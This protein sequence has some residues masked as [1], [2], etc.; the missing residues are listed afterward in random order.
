VWGIGNGSKQKRVVRD[1]ATTLRKANGETLPIPRCDPV[2]QAQSEAARGRRSDTLTAE[3]G[4][5][6]QLEAVGIRAA[7]GTILLYDIYVIEERRRTWIGSRRT[8]VQCQD[9]RC[10]R[11][12][13]PGRW[14]QG[15]LIAAPA[16]PSSAVN[17]WA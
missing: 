7:D 17:T 15:R 13:I 16:W 14:S 9:A 2:A 3:T 11:I 8:L 5:T 6:P 4:T 1:I 12:A 10:Y